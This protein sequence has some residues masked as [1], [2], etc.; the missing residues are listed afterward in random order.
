MKRT[1]IMVLC[2]VMALPLLAQNSYEE[3]KKQQQA[4]Y[5]NYRQQAKADWEAY[6]EKANK[7]FADYMKKAWQ[8]AEK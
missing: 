8:K 3:F 5:N 1:I 6:R 4:A 2:A 7:E